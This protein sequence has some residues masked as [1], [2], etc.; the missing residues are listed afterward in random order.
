MPKG[1]RLA[2]LND[3]LVLTNIFFRERSHFVVRF[4]KSDLRT[5]PVSIF[6]ETQ[7][8]RF[9]SF[10]ITFL[11]FHFRAL[12]ITDKALS[13]PNNKEI[14]YQF[15]EKKFKCD[16]CNTFFRRKDHLQEHLYVHSVGFSIC[17]IKRMHPI[18]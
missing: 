12:L 2:D 9:V 18:F 14:S 15:K 5:S 11:N 6:I 16:I 1:H 4:V 3:L 17:R 10:Q 8:I 13:D 7:F